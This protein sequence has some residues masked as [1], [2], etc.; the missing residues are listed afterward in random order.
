MGDVLLGMQPYGRALAGM[1]RNLSKG[2][3][4]RQLRA[5][6]G[7]LKLTKKQAED[8][9]LKPGEF[10][11]DT[12]EAEKAELKRMREEDREL[13]RRSAEAQLERAIPF[14]ERPPEEQEAILEGRRRLG[15]AGRRPL[16]PKEDKEL[17]ALNKR[18]RLL[19]KPPI[20]AAP[21]AVE[22]VPGMPGPVGVT[23][24]AEPP[25]TPEQLQASAAAVAPPPPPKPKLAKG[26][27][28]SATQEERDLFEQD[29]VSTE[30]V[31]ARVEKRRI[32]AKKEQDA[33]DKARIKEL[34]KKEEQETDILGTMAADPSMTEKDARTWVM[35]MK[36]SP[37]DALARREKRESEE[38]KEAQKQARENEITEDLQKIS[39]FRNRNPEIAIAIVQEAAAIPFSAASIDEKEKA[40]EFL[41]RVADAW[42]D[43][44][45][46]IGGGQ[47]TQPRDPVGPAELRRLAEEG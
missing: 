42:P 16:Q 27:Y 3:K 32:A 23:G 25:M 22:V 18:R 6:A 1:G 38:R 34:E 43:M 24:Q 47:P 7:E 10:V 5:R 20:Q 9:G 33:A 46:Y 8:L 40:R 29:E 28:E 41:K 13:Q 17:K 36:M 11:E 26:V 21:E 2:G 30:W 12:S 19:G 4:S 15:E 31:A 35:K 37:K 45:P 39:M 14:H 44:K